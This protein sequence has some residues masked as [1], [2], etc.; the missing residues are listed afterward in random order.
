MSKTG[1]GTYI[2]PRLGGG[3]VNSIS[4]D[5]LIKVVDFE[6][7]EW[8]LY[9]TFPINVALIRGTTADEKGNITF[10]KE[11]IALEVLPIAQAARA[12]GGTS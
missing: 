7:E 10:E 8:L 2:D 1:L 9:K 12:S 5:N 4:K 11:A 6:D 3:K